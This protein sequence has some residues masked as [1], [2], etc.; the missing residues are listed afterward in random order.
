MAKRDTRWKPRCLYGIYIYIYQIEKELK[1]SKP[2]TRRK[3][4]FRRSLHASYVCAHTIKGQKKHTRGYRRRTMYTRARA[5]AL[6]CVSSAYISEIDSG[7]VEPVNSESRLSHVSLLYQYWIESQERGR[8]RERQDG[9]THTR[10]HVLVYV[11][12]RA[13]KKTEEGRERDF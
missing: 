8:E 13:M 3:F 10:T 4:R 5:R 12:I 7:K 9:R 1:A 2:P 6:Y 11:Y